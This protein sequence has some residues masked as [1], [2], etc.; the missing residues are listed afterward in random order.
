MKPLIEYYKAIRTKAKVANLRKWSGKNTFSFILF[1]FF[2]ISVQ[3][4]VVH[5]VFLDDDVTSYKRFYLLEFKDSLDDGIW[6]LHNL[7]R[8]DSIK[9]SKQSV[10]AT[11]SYKDYKKEGT[12][13]YYSTSKIL[14]DGNET[15]KLKQY[16]IKRTE[17]YKAGLL[18]GMLIVRGG[19]NNGT[20]RETMYGNGKKNGLDISYREK[21]NTVLNIN[22]FSNDTLIYRF[23]YGNKNTLLFTIM[24]LDNGEYTSV[25]YDN[26]GRKKSVGY[27]DSTNYAMYKWQ[28]YYPNQ[29]VK[30]E[31]EGVILQSI[32]EMIIPPAYGADITVSSTIT[33]WGDTVA[34]VQ[35][36]ERRYNRNGVLIKEKEVEDKIDYNTMRDDKLSRYYVRTIPYIS[37]N[38]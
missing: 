20:I 19:K 13:D 28:K 16:Y 27:Y 37:I 6:I 34:A 7:E 26:K 1:A 32:K 33:D 3:A 30:K 36:V 31:K 8:K 25:V 29:V 23:Y 5:T 38:K 15:L 22:Y 35:G 10:W 14:G 9:I 11:G 2:S 24:R 18:N 4:Q 21:T 12:F 17:T